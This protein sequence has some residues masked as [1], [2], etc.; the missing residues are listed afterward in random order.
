M[1]LKMLLTSMLLVLTV[2]YAFAESPPKIVTNA[3]DAYKTKGFDEAFNIL[4]KG[5]P[6]E[7][8]KTT[9][10][11]VKGGFTQIETMYGK[12]IGYEI[13][14]SIKISNSTIRTFAEIRY[15]KGPLFV[16]IDSYN[17][18]TGWI[19]PIMRFHTNAESILPE[20]ILLKK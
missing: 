11:N 6:L 10:M 13:L 15:E 17:S 18:P 8:D 2:S 3:F 7:S 1:K 20:E 5:S 14:K 19:V 9:F 4:L 16:L 12:M